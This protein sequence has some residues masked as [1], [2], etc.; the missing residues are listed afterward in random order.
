MAVDA[1]QDVFCLEVITLAQHG[2]F[3][4]DLSFSSS[5][6]RMTICRRENVASF[7]FLLSLS[8]FLYAYVLF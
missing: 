3:A 6:E 1:L 8:P 7:M 5:V 2:K 4:M